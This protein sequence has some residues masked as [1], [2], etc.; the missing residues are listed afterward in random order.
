VSVRF[1]VDTNILTAAA[2]S[3]AQVPASLVEWMDRH[4]ERLYVSVV[5]IAEIEDG[6]AKLQREGTSRKATDLTH[7]LETLIHL[8]SARILP[9]DLGAARLAGKL[10]DTARSRGNTP[11]FAD[12][13]IAATAQHYSL[14]I[15]TRNLK[16]FTPLGVEAHDPVA[17][18]PVS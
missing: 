7:W 15:L 18:P 8:Y 12:L 14:R 13:A 6:I 4:S 17:E 16:H 5:T 10:S 3:K 11:G 1:L 2:P 9:F